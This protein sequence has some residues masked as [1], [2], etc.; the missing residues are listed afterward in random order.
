MSQFHR[1]CWLM[2]GLL[3]FSPFTKIKAQ[4]N[5]LQ[6]PSTRRVDQ[7]D[8]IHG[9]KVADPYR[10]L[11]QDV[12]NSKQVAD[13]VEAQSKLTFSY[14]QA[15]PQR[16]KIK[17]RLTDIWNF[18]QYSAA[19]K[20][21]G[22]Y[23]YFKNDGLQNQPVLYRLDSLDGEPKV[24]IDPN[25]WSKDGTIAIQGLSFSDDGKYVAY[26]RAE[27]GSDWSNWYVMEIETYKILPDELKWTKFTQPSWTKDG[28]GFFYNRFEEPSPEAKYQA[29]NFNNKL[30]YHKVGT[31]QSED[32]L[33]YWRPE[34]PEWL[35]H[36]DVSD[37]GR[38][39]V[40]T[41][42]LGSS[43]RYRIAVRDLTQLYAMTVEI[44]DNFDNE[45]SFVGNDGPVLFFKTD[46]DAPRRRL[47]TID[48]RKPNKSDWKEIIPQ[49]EDTMT[50]VNFVGDRFI[51]SYLKNVA[52]QVK[53]FAIDG[54]FMR[55][56]DL[57]GI[58]A[59]IGFEGK[60]TD[61]ETFY[62][63]SSFA[64]P[65]SIY[66]YNVI[67]GASK[68]FRRAE[69]KINTDD[70]EVK[71]VFYKS[72]DGT[73]IPMFIAHKKGVKLDGSNPTLLYGYGGFNISVLPQFSISRVAW[74]E[75][76]GIYAQPNLRG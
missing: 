42:E 1:I 29:L 24:L 70:Y 11:E 26:S 49:T 23:F 62:M 56:V 36:P 30:Y 12:R 64:T 10:W 2:V 71:Q 4:E 39:L 5:K 31:P 34:H 46:L 69:A 72:K 47:I 7:V 38:Y 27:A 25:Q 65:P 63:F 43:D 33:V 53:I 22:R 18:A 8:V 28:R 45:Y 37:D 73:R 14:L 57:P 3:L 58:G 21:G 20:E 13:W 41:I 6:Y 68:L 59:V 50:D 9:V 76:G 44:I 35:Y 55:E 66:H 15:I 52:A 17:Q 32:V 67:T 75:L 54:R 19:R 51:A 61:I 40:I 74:M 48:L 60:R 16:D